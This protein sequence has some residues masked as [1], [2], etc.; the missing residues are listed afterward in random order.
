MENR[1]NYGKYQQKYFKNIKIIG[2]VYLE[3]RFSCKKNCKYALQML[4]FTVEYM[5]NTIPELQ[6]DI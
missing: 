4:Q 2:M 3:R 1:W 5:K 6:V